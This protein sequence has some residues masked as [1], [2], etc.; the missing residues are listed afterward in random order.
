MGAFVFLGQGEYLMERGDI[1]AVSDLTAD[2]NE[3]IMC[4][5]LVVSPESFNMLTQRPVVLSISK[6]GDFTRVAGFV[7]T[8]DGTETKTRGIVRCD[9]PSILDSKA[10]HWEKIEKI[11]CELMKEILA[12]LTPIFD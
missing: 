3:R 12:R 4:T 2:R 1:Y 11:P 6:G 10:H 8:L 7:V 9:Q 5:V